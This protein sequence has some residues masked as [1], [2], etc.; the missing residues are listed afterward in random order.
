MSTSRRL[1]VLGIKEV[2]LSSKLSA[3]QMEILLRSALP[4]VQTMGAFEE[5]NQAGVSEVGLRVVLL[6]RKHSS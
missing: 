6:A 4:A 1:Q 2:S 3:V 5:A